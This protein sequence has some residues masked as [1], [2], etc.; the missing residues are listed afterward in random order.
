MS[1]RDYYTAPTTPPQPKQ[2]S[3]PAAPTTVLPP[4]PLNEDQAAVVAK[5][6]SSIPSVTAAVAGVGAG[7]ALV[8][9]TIDKPL[10]PPTVSDGRK[11]CES[12]HRYL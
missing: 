10:P 9:S 7:D 4:A 1:W 2:E 8:L 6:L 11:L 3:V 12:I 5:A